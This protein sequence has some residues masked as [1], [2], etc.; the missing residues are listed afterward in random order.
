[1]KLNK[2]F[3]KLLLLGGSCFVV[4]L[5][6]EI[7]LRLFWKPQL[8]SWQRNISTSIDIDPK[9]I[10]GVTGPARISTNSYGLRG[11]DWSTDRAKEYRIL[12]IGGSTTECL[13]NDQPNTWPSLL[14]TRL[15]TMD[16]RKVWVG[17]AGHGGFDSR[18]HVLEMRFMLD[19]YDP[20]AVVILV[21]GNDMGVLLNEGMGYDPNFTANS[22]KMRSLALADFPENPISLLKQPEDSR[23]KFIRNS[24]LYMYLREFVRRYLQPRHGMV[25]NV[26]LYRQLREKRRSP[27]AI[28][29]EK[30]SDLKL[31]LSGYERNL[32]EIIHL[33]RQRQVRLILLTQPTL[34]QPNMSSEMINSLWAG[35]VGDPALNIYWSPEVADAVMN[36]HNKL[37]LE[38]CRMESIE[39]IDLAAT[40]PKT[41]DVFFDQCHFTDRGCSLVADVV[42]NYFKNNPPAVP[43]NLKR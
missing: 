12:T 21:G 6:A 38:V 31:G 3:G 33:A 23:F 15:A 40:L 27:W 4:L 32:R 37:L 26:D 20:D 9:I 30:P 43:S 35:W 13:L 24:Y 16:Q 2:T 28:V 42:V 1:M 14:Q 34:F 8:T 11:D 19:Q 36:E 10:P 29:R 18:H 41:L 25:H 39:C 7:G 5:V 22:H 17:N